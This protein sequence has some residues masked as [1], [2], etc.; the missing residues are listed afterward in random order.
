MNWAVSKSLN[1]RGF[2]ALWLDGSAPAKAERAYND[3]PLSFLF[4]FLF[5]TP[6][7]R[8]SSCG[9]FHGRCSF[10]AFLLGSWKT[11]SSSSSR[12]SLW[13]WQEAKNR[14]RPSETPQQVDNLISPFRRKAKRMRTLIPRVTYYQSRIVR[15]RRRLVARLDIEHYYVLPAVQ[16]FSLRRVPSFLFVCSFRW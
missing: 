5:F 4:S 9:F 8:A 7:L 1:I 12:P 10:Y 6:L 2:W 15:R 16:F 14:K 3:P 11:T 13:C